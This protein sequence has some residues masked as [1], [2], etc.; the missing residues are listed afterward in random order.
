MNDMSNRRDYTNQHGVYT[1]TESSAI[2]NIE[3]KKPQA[4]EST[5][6]KKHTSVLHEEDM[7]ALDKKRKSFIDFMK[8]TLEKEGDENAEE[9]VEAYKK[10]KNTYCREYYESNKERAREANRRYRERHREELREYSHKYYE[11]HT[12]LKRQEEKEEKSLHTYKD[13][14]GIRL[15]REG[16]K[17]VGWYR[18]DGCE[19]NDEE[20]RK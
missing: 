3:G 5:H 14:D 19:Q 11:T 15:V 6:V 16:R 9:K 13:I 4:D 1:P 12:K 18:P 7:R 17:I 20:T 2:Y 10:A 8:E